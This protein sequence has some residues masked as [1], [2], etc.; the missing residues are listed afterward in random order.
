MGEHTVADVFT[1]A[2]TGWD[3]WKAEDGSTAADLAEQSGA[4]GINAMIQ[5]KLQGES[6]GSWPQ[7]FDF[8]PDT[9]KWIDDSLDGGQTD[10][11]T[12]DWLPV[13]ESPHESA[14]PLASALPS[15]ATRLA[16]AEA[17]LVDAPGDSTTDGQGNFLAMS[18]PSSS[19]AG[20]DLQKSGD[21][22]EVLHKGLHQRGKVVGLGSGVYSDNDHLYLD[23]KVHG[24]NVVPRVFDAQAALVS[25]AVVGAVGVCALGLRFCFEYYDI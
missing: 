13:T 10:S 7:Q 14:P 19:G 16:G 8:D 12:A 6:S 21:F 9:G 2:L 4:P 3:S 5:R 23:Q 1:D 25:S 18:S 22:G 17:S 24:K 20:D 11:Q 15:N